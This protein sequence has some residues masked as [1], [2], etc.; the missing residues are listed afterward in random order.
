MRKFS[1]TIA[2]L[3]AVSATVACGG[4]RAGSGNAWGFD[5]TPSSSNPPNPD[6]MTDP[7]PVPD[8]G[9]DPVPDPGPDPA[10]DPGPDPDPDPGPGTEPSVEPCSL[11]DP[12]ARCA[13]NP[14]DDPWATAAILDELRIAGTEDSP[15]CCFDFTGDNV[16][17]NS[18]GQNM[19]GFGFLTETNAA[20]R[21]AMA[22]G[23]PAIILE[24]DGLGAN[25]TGP[26]LLDYWLGAWA[27]SMTAIAPTDNDVLV[28]VGSIDAGAQPFTYFA[29]AVLQGT[30]LTASGGTVELPITLLGPVIPLTFRNA[31]IEADLEGTAF[32]TMRGKLG[33]AVL[34]DDIF[35][36][37]NHYVSQNCSCLALDGPLIG[38]GTGACAPEATPDAC[39]AEC[40]EF[41]ETCNLYGAIPLFADVDRDGDGLNDSMTIGMSFHAVPATI[42]GTTN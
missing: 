32:P 4:D 22:V 3:L 26:F 41:A 2:L 7:T 34:V 28:S 12:P 19:A 1:M 14:D 21:D 17:D 29:S 42:V 20:L 8:P 31:R 35:G 11:P 5:E 39:G 13:A 16:I 30:H 9:P 27:P 25:R 18:L 24:L 23:E 10:P 33:G 37:V 6:P 38:K 36:A 40:R 15:Q